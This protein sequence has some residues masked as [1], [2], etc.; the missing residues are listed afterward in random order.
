[1]F[2]PEHLAG[3]SKTRLDFV[4]DKYRPVFSAKLLRV[5]EEIGLRRLAALAL[6]RLD[7]ERRNVALRQLTL[8]R[9]DV[10]QRHASVE[11]FHERPEAF[12]ETFA[13]HQR[14]RTETEPVKYALERDDP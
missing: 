5:L 1:M 7:Y 4:A 11:A 12:C 14:E 2:E 13:T 10:I 3:A 6:H 8:E 9:S